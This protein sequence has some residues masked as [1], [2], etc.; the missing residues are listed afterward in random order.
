MKNLPTGA[1]TPHGNGLPD[2]GQ[3][4]PLIEPG[5]ETPMTDVG[6]GAITAR[7]AASFREE[8]LSLPSSGRINEAGSS[9]VGDA[10]P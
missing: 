4:P 1:R 8:K 7:M 10:H 2:A 3:M 6:M 5:G 9:T